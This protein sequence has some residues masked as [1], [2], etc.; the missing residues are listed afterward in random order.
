M[1]QDEAVLRAHWQ[2]FH[3][4]TISF[5]D[6]VEWRGD[7]FAYRPEWND[8]KDVGEL[9]GEEVRF[10]IEMKEGILYSIRVPVN[11]GFMI[12]PMKRM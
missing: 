5:E 7:D 10:E 9:V 3:D 2:R 4:G 8:K 11:P 12:P 6:A 1:R